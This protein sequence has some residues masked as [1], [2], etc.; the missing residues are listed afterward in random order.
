MASLDYQ[1]ESCRLASFTEWPL[2]DGVS[3][4]SLAHSGF[5]YGGSEHYVCCWRCKKAIDIGT[6]GD[7]YKHFHRMISPDCED[8]PADLF[9]IS[10]QLPDYNINP[11]GIT[12][13]DDSSK[14]SE[15]ELI[16]E[17]VKVRAAGRGIFDAK[18]KLALNEPDFDLL[19]RELVR[20][21]TFRIW[22]STNSARPDDLVKAA[23]FYTGTGDQVRCAFCRVVKASWI[24][25]DVP[26]DEHQKISPDCPFIC[27]N[28]TLCDN[29]PCNE[30]VLEQEI[31][32][33][34]FDSP[35]IVELA[36]VNASYSLYS[37]DRGTKVTPA[38]QALSNVRSDRPI[39]TLCG[40]KAKNPKMSIAHERMQ[41]FKRPEAVIPNNQSPD[42]LAE[43]GFYYVGPSDLCRCFFCG[44][45]VKEWLP[46]DDPWIEH[47]KF[48]PH[49]EHVK[50]VKGE[51][52]IRDIQGTAPEPLISVAS[53]SVQ[54]N[55][56]DAQSSSLPSSV[57]GSNSLK[58][59]GNYSLPPPRGASVAA[60]GSVHGAKVEES[61]QSAKSKNKNKKKKKKAS[62]AKSSSVTHSSNIRQAGSQE[63]E[64]SQAAA[65]AAALNSE[66]VAVA[67]NELEILEN[68][69][70]I[71]NDARMCKIC[72]TNEVNAVFLPC[73]H[74]VSCENCVS[75]LRICMIC[76]TV[77]RGTVKT[78]FE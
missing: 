21:Q 4:V 50:S 29:I 19:R 39:D 26:N 59:E 32:L 74:L 45:G 54:D 47:A 65:P 55:L 46:D 49:C 14:R 25:A 41:T 36:A 11:R 28:R 2:L 62:E 37:H 60:T 20:L 5:Y 23:F 48:Y 56:Q 7:K 72:R 43:A 40:V 42:I 34:G 3:S 58:P 66:T 16:L 6:V 69:N 17:S 52:F 10:L 13:A 38:A 75:D 24:P 63:T 64:L 67:A 71:L 51:E 53:L 68:E 18:I 35:D 30:D 12:Q 31:E 15:S 27:G 8:L 44:G 76:R 22:P 77:I 70:R 78:F 73:G 33:I 61:K 57:S 1:K 9:N